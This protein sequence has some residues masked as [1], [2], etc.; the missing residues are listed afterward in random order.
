MSADDQS[1]HSSIAEWAYL[2]WEARGRPA[3]SA[4]QDWLEAER[5]FAASK[6]ARGAAAKKAVAAEPGADE[7]AKVAPERVKDDRR[8]SRAKK[9]LLTDK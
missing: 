3:G 2:L 7:P 1:D 9:P 4:A 6:A 5:L 8:K